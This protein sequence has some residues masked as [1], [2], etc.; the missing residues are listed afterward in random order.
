[1]VYRSPRAP[2]AAEAALAGFVD[3][4]DGGTRTF[5]AS[6]ATIARLRNDVP[7]AQSGESGGSAALPAV[8]SGAAN[9]AEAEVTPGSV[10][11]AA[12][13]TAPPKEEGAKGQVNLETLAR[14]IYDRLRLRLQVDRERAGIGAR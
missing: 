14:Q 4:V 8:Q 6:P 7:A 9:G 5:Q 1:M 3:G 2:L 13:V 10:G 11:P 12:D